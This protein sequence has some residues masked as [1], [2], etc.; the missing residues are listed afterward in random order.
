LSN[1]LFINQGLKDGV[2]SFKELSKNTLDAPGTQ[3]T[4]AA[5]F[6]YDK[7][8]DLDFCSIIRTIPTTISIRG[9]SVRPLISLG[10]LIQE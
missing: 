9:R 4:Q 1:E 10:A 6:D 5:F 3:S 8:G 2:P 7:D